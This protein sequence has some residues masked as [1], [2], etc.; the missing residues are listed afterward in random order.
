MFAGYE[1]Y[2]DFD[3]L[4]LRSHNFL[5]NWYAVLSVFFLFLPNIVDLKDEVAWYD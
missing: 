2:F 1:N 5:H 3:K 4:V